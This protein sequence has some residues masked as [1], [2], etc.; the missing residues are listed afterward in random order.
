VVEGN[1]DHRAADRLSIVVAPVAVALT[2]FG[3][4]VAQ[5]RVKRQVG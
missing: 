4:V 2:D 5:D 1:V 3:G